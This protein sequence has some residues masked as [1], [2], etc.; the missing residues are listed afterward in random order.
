VQSFHVT[1][2]AHPVKG[3]GRKRMQQVESV[4]EREES[5]GADMHNDE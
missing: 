2:M 5:Q 4:S 1:S 3:V